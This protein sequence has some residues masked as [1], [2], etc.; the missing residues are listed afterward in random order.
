[1]RQHR[2]EP[3]SSQENA[4][5]C[6]TT[7]SSCVDVV[8]GGEQGHEE[9]ISVLEV[10]L[11]TAR[12]PFCLSLRHSRRGCCS[13]LRGW[14][15]AAALLALAQPAGPGAQLCRLPSPTLWL[16]CPSWVTDGAVQILWLLGSC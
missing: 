5:G 1:M 9:L 3:G 4:E 16:L 14:M 12:A 7:Q 6:G 11:P 10:R 2:E 8:G 13:L 15:A